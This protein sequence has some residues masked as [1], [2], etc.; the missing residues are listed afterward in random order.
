METELTGHDRKTSSFNKQQYCVEETKKPLPQEHTT[1]LRFCER[2]IVKQILQMIQMK[3]A[4][5]WYS[6]TVPNASTFPALTM[7]T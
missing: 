6:T 5:S 2:K 3:S 7:S 4:G 1:K